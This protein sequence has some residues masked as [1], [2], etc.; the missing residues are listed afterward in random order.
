MGVQERALK[1]YPDVRYFVELVKIHLY[2]SFPSQ[3]LGLPC[4]TPA[5]Q[6][7]SLSLCIKKRVFAA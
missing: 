5:A 1:L 7:F 3:M 2:S 4:M 6:H